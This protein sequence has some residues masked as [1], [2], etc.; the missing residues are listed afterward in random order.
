M[1]PIPADEFSD[2]SEVDIPEDTQVSN[3]NSVYINGIPQDQLSVIA[4]NGKNVNVSQCAY[5]TK[6][7][8]SNGDENMGSFEYDTEGNFVCFHCMF[9]I[10]YDIE[11]RPIV[12]GVYGK[13]ILEYVIQCKDSHD[14]NKCPRNGNECF[15]CDNIKG[16][17]I[18]GI[19]GSDTLVPNNTKNTDEHIIKI[20][21]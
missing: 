11:A 7:Y 14:T 9:S 2:D 17:I 20:S 19:F 5:C 21:I 15:I 6:Y 12:D 13:T 3:S 18:E 1:N 10:N 16:I 8:H 4:N